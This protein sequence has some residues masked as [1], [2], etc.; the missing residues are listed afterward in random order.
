MP[1]HATRNNK[2]KKAVAAATLA[3][4]AAAALTTT[5][6]AAA[7]L[8]TKSRPLHFILSADDGTYSGTHEQKYILERTTITRNFTAE[9]P[10]CQSAYMGTIDISKKS[11]LLGG[12]GAGSASV[13]AVLVTSGIGAVT[14]ALCTQQASEW[15]QR[16]ENNPNPFTAAYFMGTSGW[17]PY[18]GGLNPKATDGSCGV[19]RTNRHTKSE[20]VSIGSVCVSPLSYDIDCGFH[21]EDPKKSGADG[22][23]HNLEYSDTWHKSDLFGKCAY[24]SVK[25]GG[26]DLAGNILAATEAAPNS[27]PKMDN[28]LTNRVTTFWAAMQLG[29]Q[30][31]DFE[32]P[33]TPFVTTRC[34]EAV[35]H[36]IWVGAQMDYQCRVLTGKLLAEAGLLSTA[37]QTGSSASAGDEDSF[38]CS[39]AMEGYGF[40]SAITRHL[41][42]LPSVIIR[43]A[44]NYDMYPLFK[45]TNG[46]NKN[47]WEQNPN[48]VSRADELA[49]SSAG[50]HYSILTTNTVL[51][52]YLRT[53]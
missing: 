36:A 41:P 3:V 5:T 9:V 44:S 13:D 29:K 23:C 38:V 4:V 22:E 26:A 32:I 34:A 7:P 19:N 40:L 51:L 39:S 27:I 47:Y 15:V 45:S 24:N 28:D 11:G 31:P 8:K 53:L 10:F 33:Y 49:F 42:N 12:I 21:V 43:G 20:R 52:N 6:A 2:P 30:A 50:Y 1:T 18:I 14:A 46:N 25:A 16:A 35:G 48:Y 17:S 37:R